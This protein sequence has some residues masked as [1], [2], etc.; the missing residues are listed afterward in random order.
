V[1]PNEREHTRLGCGR[2]YR[3]AIE[4]TLRVLP[5]RSAGGGC[6]PFVPTA[7]ISGAEHTAR[8]RRRREERTERRLLRE[9]ASQQAAQPSW[10]RSMQLTFAVAVC[11]SRE[12]RRCGCEDARG[13]ACGQEALAPHIETIASIQTDPGFANAIA[14]ND[15]APPDVDESRMK[16]EE[17]KS[18]T[19]APVHPAPDC[20]RLQ[21]LAKTVS[22]LRSILDFH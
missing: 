11:A 9:D 2:T 1:L 18:R 16:V 22:W 17:Q 7:R 5:S 4:A 3:R 6:A 8:E 15:L 13:H 21:N 20:S 19:T 10:M 14:R 12:R